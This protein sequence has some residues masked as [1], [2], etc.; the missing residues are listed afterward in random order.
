MC[1]EETQELCEQKQDEEGNFYD[2][3]DCEELE[4]TVC[5]EV[6]EEEE[7]SI[8]ITYRVFESIKDNA[9]QG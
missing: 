7:A 6:P 2:T 1:S 4:K 5:E 3:D 9:A 8:Y